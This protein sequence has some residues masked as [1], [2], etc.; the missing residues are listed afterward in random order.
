VLVAAMLSEAFFSTD[1][2]QV[3]AAPRRR[4][5]RKVHSAPWVRMS[6]AGAENN[7]TGGLPGSFCQKR[8]SS[9]QV[10]EESSAIANGGAV[11]R[12]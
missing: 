11:L 2:E 9:D 5:R 7:T 10:V 12:Y 4:C 1:M 3:V 8:D 6:F